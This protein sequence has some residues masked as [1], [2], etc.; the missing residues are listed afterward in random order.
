MSY[1]LFS[2]LDAA[3]KPRAGIATESGHFDLGCLDLSNVNSVDFDINQLDVDSVLE[4]WPQAH[5]QLKTLATAVSED[6]S[7]GA[8]AKLDANALS[9]A[10]PLNR[11][12]IIYAAGAN[13]RDHVEA[14]GRAFNMQLTLD[15]RADGIPPW[16]FIKAGRA[17]LAGHKQNVVYPD[18]T[19][20][21]DWE[22]ELAVIIGRPAQNVSVDDALS[23]VAGY[24]VAND[25]SARD[26]LRR[27]QVDPSSPFRFDWI[28]HK[29]FTGACPLGPYFTPA[30][31]V[32]SPENLGIKLWLNG[33]L[34][35]DSNTR[36][37]LY[38][39]ADQIAYLS[40][41]LTLYPGDII[42]TGTPA[43]VGMET[44]TFLERG[45]VMK[46]WIE[47]L[48]QLETTIV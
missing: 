34:K 9:F 27:D 11:P 17:T 33:E 44:G 29:C 39:V 45:D 24:T 18:H 8:N 36:N 7:I 28:G 47:S 48:G 5:E 15:P 13:Y 32:A 41:R 19:Q 6:S 40:G 38:S 31:F 2:Y 43:G 12:G 14:M 25:L 26:N 20:R 4:Q 30:E 46:V 22:A 42:L 16:H 10:A 35:Q 37:H 23:Y 3:G 21:L 1:Q